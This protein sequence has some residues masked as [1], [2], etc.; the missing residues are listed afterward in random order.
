MGSRCTLFSA[1]MDLVEAI[2]SVML[3]HWL[4]RLGEAR[5]LQQGLRPLQTVKLDQALPRMVG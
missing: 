1:S 3:P 4:E 5:P 2:L